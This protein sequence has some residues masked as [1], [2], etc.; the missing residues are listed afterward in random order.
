MPILLSAH[1]VM[2]LVH[3]TMIVHKTPSLHI[4][5][6]KCITLISPMVFEFQGQRY[7]TTL[8]TNRRG[9]SREACG[10][11]HAGKIV[12]IECRV[13]SHIPSAQTRLFAPH[14]HHNSAIPL[15]R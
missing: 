8:D 1:P 14:S 7:A 9:N 12:H 6:G 3:V 10:G 4:V 15:Q 2:V 5:I 13:I 11:Q